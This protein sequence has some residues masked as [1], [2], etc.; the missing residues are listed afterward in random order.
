M[1]L[2]EQRGMELAA[3]RTI[4]Q[5]AGIWIV[6]SQAGKGAY[7]VHLMP[8]I[9]SCT[10]PDFETRGVN[11]K[12]IF[13][14]RFVMRREQNADGSTTVTKSVTFTEKTTY[15]QVWSAYNEAQTNEQDKF[16]SLLHDLCS[17]LIS[18]PSKNG[19]PRLPLSDAVFNVAFKVYSTISQRRFM[20]DLRE[21]HRR[22]YISKVPH[23]NSISNY[24]EKPELTSILQNFI[25]QTSL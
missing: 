15:P 11:C 12:H 17:G 24:L 25:T 5:K 10:C 1:D 13:A 21:A 23:F 6:P 7:R 2:R 8:K 22:G 9:A 3:T 14:A 4:N 16:Q 18:A 20:S 19:R